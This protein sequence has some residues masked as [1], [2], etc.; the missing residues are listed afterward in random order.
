M[1]LLERARKEADRR[2]GP[3]WEPSVLEGGL[4]MCPMCGITRGNTTA[5]KALLCCLA[6]VQAGDHK[7]HYRD[8]PEVPVDEAVVIAELNRGHGSAYIRQKYGYSYKPIL[9]VVRKMM[10][11][12]GLDQYQ[13]GIWLRKQLR[14]S[15]ESGLLKAM[16]K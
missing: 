9:K 5:E 2:Y 14:K 12:K 1:T 3:D 4:F 16:E 13:F 7:A 10:A 11:E 6:T 15:N 8:I